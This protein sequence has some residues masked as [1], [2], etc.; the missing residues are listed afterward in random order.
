MKKHTIL[1]LLISFLCACSDDKTDMPQIELLTV[2]LNGGDED[3]SRNLQDILPLSPGDYIDVSF[4]LSGNGTDLKTFMVKKGSENLISTLFF[5]GDEVSDEFSDLSEGVLG[6]KDGVKA[7]YIA[8]KLK[9]NA[10]KDEDVRVAFYLNSKAADCEGA[11]YYLDLETT[12]DLRLDNLQL[13]D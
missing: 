4:L 6:Y 9:V 10:G 13:D 5:Y 7:T 3:Y 11:V 8:V 2:S 12:K 1:L